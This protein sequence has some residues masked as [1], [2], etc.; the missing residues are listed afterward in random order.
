M[1]S[2]TSIHTIEKEVAVFHII[3]MA[4]RDLEAVAALSAQDMEQ[5]GVQA[6]PDAQLQLF[7]DVLNDPTGR[8]RCWVARSAEGEVGGFVLV[9]VLWSAKFSGQSAWIEQLYV[10]PSGRRQGLG[11]RLVEAVLGW[12][13]AAPLCGV[14]L[15]AYR[16]NTP[17]AVLYR[18]LGF[19]RLGR[20]RFGLKLGA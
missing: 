3:E 4:Q 15:E 5:L 16:D 19:R 1:T 9:N 20:E 7:T 12:A 11:R 14:D 6:R 18:S 13:E 17:A 10:P 8:A 2:D